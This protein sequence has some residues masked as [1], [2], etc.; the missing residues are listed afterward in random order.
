MR[1]TSQTEND[2]RRA[3][4][5]GPPTRKT[6]RFPNHVSN[7]AACPPGGQAGEL[8]RFAPVYRGSMGTAS[9]VRDVPRGFGSLWENKGYG[10][11]ARRRGL[12]SPMGKVDFGEMASHFAERRM[13]SSRF[14]SRQCCNQN[15]KPS[16]KDLIRPLRGHLPQRGKA[17][18]AV[19]CASI[20]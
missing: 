1:H 8:R 7:S 12:P 20:V 5:R 14:A 13:R 10:R 15:A 2:C 18:V 6:F 4:L 17:W 3:A 11:H 16:L 9:F 19:P